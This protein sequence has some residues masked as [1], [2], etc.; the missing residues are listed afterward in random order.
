MRK[1]IYVSPF[2]PAEWVAAHGMQPC[3]V[4]LDRAEEGWRAGPTAG[5]CSF[6]REFIT[7][8][9][10]ENAASAIIATTECD[11]M[12][13]AG[14]LIARDSSVPVFVMHV[15]TTWQTAAAQ[16]LYMTELERLGRFL[17]RLG[18]KSSSKESLTSTMLKYD[19]E[20]SRI[21]AARGYLSARQ[22]SE[23]IAD[24]NQTGEV[25]LPSARRAFVPRRVGVA[26][27]GGPLLR[28]HF[29]FFDFVE[30]AGGSIVL[31]GSETG[32]RTMPAAFDRRQVEEDPLIELADAYFGNIPDAF[33][34]PNSELYRWLKN[35][36][37]DRGVRGIVLLRYLW[38]DTW[39]AEVQRLKEWAE[40]PILDLDIGDTDSHERTA[41]RIQSFVAMLR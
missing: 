25:V 30:N 24:F 4:L 20:R 17:V 41:S 35:E 15:P 8:A 21:R 34:R 22:L 5:I 26:L 3:R 16:K 38:C 33:R 29:R 36:I 10:S 18:G 14:E 19:A 1:V 27:V 32:E 39:H 2:V 11:Q 40:V 12:R 28:D 23:A 7:Y 9:L 6:A 31:D 37:A 13:R